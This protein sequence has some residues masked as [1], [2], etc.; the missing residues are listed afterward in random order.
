[1]LRVLKP[2]R[3]GGVD[4]K[5]GKP[6]PAGLSEKLIELLKRTRYLEEIRDEPKQPRGK[7]R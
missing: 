5:S 3:E 1:M 4:Y 2:F 6:A 7:A